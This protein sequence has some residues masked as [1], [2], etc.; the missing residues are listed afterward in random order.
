MKS[1]FIATQGPL[2]PTV[3]DFWRMIWKEKCR[4]IVM[5]TN[6]VEGN[7]V[8]CEEYW[9]LKEQ[10]LAEGPFVVELLSEEPYANFTIRNLKILVC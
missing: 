1:K 4:V 10:N 6:K 7:R 8:K 2:L 3:G 9:P 5:L